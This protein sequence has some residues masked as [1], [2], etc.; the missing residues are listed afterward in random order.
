MTTFSTLVAF[1]GH[2]TLTHLRG[3][4]NF[5]HRTRI[6]HQFCFPPALSTPKSGVDRTALA[7]R[8]PF[9]PTNCYSICCTRSGLGPLAF[10]CFA[11]IRVWLLLSRSRLFA[12]RNSRPVESCG[13]TAYA[14]VAVRTNHV[15]RR[16]SLIFL[17][18]AGCQINLSH[19]IGFRLDT[20]L[21]EHS[22][23]RRPSNLGR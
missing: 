21:L 15:R 14:S 4:P 12:H 9:P 22:Q 13:L 11:V 1:A 6:C 16:H 20:T 3:H 2:L 18:Y 19:L 8:L 17:S 5:N 23:F 10:S 7:L